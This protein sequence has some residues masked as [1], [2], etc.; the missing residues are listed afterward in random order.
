M[1]YDVS[2]TNL[3]RD[4]KLEVQ[5]NG[6]HLKRLK[7]P[8]TLLFADKFISVAKM[9]THYHEVISCVMKNQFGLLPQ[10]YKNGFHPYLS[11]ILTDLNGFYH[12]DIC[13][14]DGIVGLEGDGPTDGTPRNFGI[15]VLGTNPVSTDSVAARIMGFNPK[16]I[17]H[18][19][20]AKDKIGTFHF[21]ELG[22]PLKLKKVKFIPILVF[23]SL[24]IAL[25]F[26]KHHFPK[27]AK[28][29]YSFAKKFSLIWSIGKIRRN[30][31]RKQLK[32]IL[33]GVKR[34]ISI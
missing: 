22:D 2:L 13:I 18:L 21:T 31:K 32:L 5:I 29:F 20:Y 9:K 17:P 24:R 34:L 6:K 15:I 25:Y 28:I 10:R 4:K 16:K 27:A 19:K 7:V 26:E 1:K 30:P 12:P 11:E 23:K 8:L 3:S 14:V 33:K